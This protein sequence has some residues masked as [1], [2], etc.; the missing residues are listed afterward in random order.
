MQI[1]IRYSLP[2]LLRVSKWTAQGGIRKKGEGEGR[3]FWGR[4]QL[5]PRRFVDF[6]IF[7]ILKLRVGIVFS[8]HCLL[9]FFILY[10][11]AAFL[12]FFFSFLVSSNEYW[13]RLPAIIL[14]EVQ[15][16]EMDGIICCLNKTILKQCYALLFIH[17]K[18]SL[19]KRPLA[20]TTNYSSRCCP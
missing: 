15:I 5:V 6:L 20:K 16:M 14:C 12:V 13:C 2:Q 8:R 9:A 18:S 7:S 3:G 10:Y 11:I 17:I 4:A 19:L 1:F